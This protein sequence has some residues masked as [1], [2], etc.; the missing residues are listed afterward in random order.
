MVKNLINDKCMYKRMSYF[1]LT[2]LYIHFFL[3]N[4][5]AYISPQENV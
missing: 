2:S 3:A 4:N 5:K 1:R